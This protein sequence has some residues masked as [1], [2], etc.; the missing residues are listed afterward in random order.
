MPWHC[1]H[2]CHIATDCNTGFRC[3]NTVQTLAQQYWNI[4]GK[5][6]SVAALIQS[7]QPSPPPPLV[8]VGPPSSLSDNSSLVAAIVA[9]VGTC[10]LMALIATIVYVKHRRNQNHRSLLGKV[11]APGVSP[12]TT[13]VITDVQVGVSWLS[14]K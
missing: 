6:G 3:V 10:V 13:L 2:G 1:I 12:N 7:R 4:L 5:P 14:D 9:P 11:L 8:I